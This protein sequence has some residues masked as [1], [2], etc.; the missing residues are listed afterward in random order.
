MSESQVASVIYQ[1]VNGIQYLKDCG[2]AHRDLKPA[3]ILVERNFNSWQNIKVKIT[4]FGLS[5]IFDPTDKQFDSCGTLSYIAPEVLT[6]KGYG[7]EVDMWSI[8]CIFYKMLTDK[9]PF[10]A[11][12]QRTMIHKIVE[13]TPDFQLNSFCYSTLE[14]RDM[15]VR[16]LNKD[17]EERISVEEALHH[18]LFEVKGI[19]C[20]KEMTIC[21]P[22][23]SCKDE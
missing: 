20:R 10:S 17:P 19:I 18:K 23:H 21:E 8:G 15:L 14:S 16:M 13:T 11:E 22:A 6:K 9:S 12:S 5:K 2:I 3:N 4:D 7:H 1:L